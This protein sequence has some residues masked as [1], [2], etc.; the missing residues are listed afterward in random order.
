MK[1]EINIQCAVH[2]LKINIMKQTERNKN[3]FH[4]E[5]WKYGSREII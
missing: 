1:N 2:L 5:I 4:I 3:Y